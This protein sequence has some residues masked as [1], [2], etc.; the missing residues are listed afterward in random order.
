MSSNATFFH[1]RRY[2]LHILHFST[3]YK[4]LKGIVTSLQNFYISISFNGN[5]LLKV[6]SSKQKSLSW[7]VQ[8]LVI[9]D[10]TGKLANIL[11]THGYSG[12]H[13]WERYLSN[14]NTAYNKTVSRIPM[15]WINW[16]WSDKTMSDGVSSNCLLCKLVYSVPLHHYNFVRLKHC[17]FLPYPSLNG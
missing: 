2:S 15:N 17:Y 7:S 4:I 10:S 14:I 16:I 5:S 1:Q 6:N 13:K 12:F 9:W 11:L 3:I 8:K